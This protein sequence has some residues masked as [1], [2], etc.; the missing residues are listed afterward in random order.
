MA[1]LDFKS[2]STSQHSRIALANASIRRTG[3]RNLPIGGQRVLT[4]PRP[5]SVFPIPRQFPKGVHSFLEGVTLAQDPQFSDQFCAT[6]FQRQYERRSHRRCG[7]LFPL[8]VADW[9]GSAFAGWRHPRTHVERLD[10][11]RRFDAFKPPSVSLFLR[12]GPIWEILRRHLHP[13]IGNEHAEY[14]SPASAA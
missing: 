5:L 6:I 2:L 12:T 1:P 7:S 14:D 3:H 13:A 9:I 8:F 4:Q 10:F 11:I